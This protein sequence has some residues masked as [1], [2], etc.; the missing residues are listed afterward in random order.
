MLPESAA[1]RK[2]IIVTGGVGF[3]GSNFAEQSIAEGN[4]VTID[5]LTHADNQAELE[6][7]SRHAFVHGDICDAVAVTELFREFRA[8]EIV[9]FAAES[10]VDRSIV[11]P[12][13]LIRTNVQGPLPLLQQAKTVPVQPPRP[14]LITWFAPT[15][16]PAA[17]QP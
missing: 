10:H 12:G 14:A 11:N 7:N 13:A 9:H 15:F 16:T 17:F 8:Y 1:Q 5:L 3:I 2:R 6:P 4:I